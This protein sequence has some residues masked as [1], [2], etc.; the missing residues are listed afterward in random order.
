M[1]KIHIYFSTIILVP[2]KGLGIL[3]VQLLSAVTYA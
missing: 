3:C 1:F 2:L